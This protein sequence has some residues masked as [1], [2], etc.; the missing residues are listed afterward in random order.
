MKKKRI[1]VKISYDQTHDGK[2]FIDTADQGRIHCKNRTNDEKV[3]LVRK[4]NSVAS[5]YVRGGVPRVNQRL[6]VIVEPERLKAALGVKQEIEVEIKPERFKATLGGLPRVNQRLRVI[7]ESE[8]LKAALGEKQEIE[9]EIKPERFKATL[10]GLPRVN[11]RLLV[12]IKPE[13]LKAALSEEQEIE[14]VIKPEDIKTVRGRISQK[15]NN[16]FRRK[17]RVNRKACGGG[18]DKP[19]FDECRSR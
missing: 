16:T 9:V 1:G 18:R 2:V 13:R 7:I 15:R 19:D 4:T 14:V 10:G 5:K 8:R 3:F 11:Q 12:L 6:R 17:S